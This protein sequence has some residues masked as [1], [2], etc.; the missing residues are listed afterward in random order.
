MAIPSHWYQLLPLHPASP[1]NG[2]WLV[3]KPDSHIAS[4]KVCVGYKAR[5]PKLCNLRKHG[6]SACHLR[7]ARSFLKLPLSVGDPAKREYP[8]Q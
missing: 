1:E 7:L 5:L 6:R 4:C 8:N 3:E 2:S